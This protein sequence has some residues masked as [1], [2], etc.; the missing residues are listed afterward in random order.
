MAIN[1][2]EDIFV[3]Y[4][5]DTIERVVKDIRANNSRLKK[6][7]AISANLLTNDVQNFANQYRAF[8]DMN[9]GWFDLADNG[10]DDDAMYVPVVPALSTAFYQ[11]Q[12]IDE[13]RVTN[14]P[15]ILEDLLK[16]KK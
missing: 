12:L 4:C 7:F 10:E 3:A 16:H 14:Q 6:N 11:L 5:E 13:F 15:K 1:E 2:V 8:R 9:P